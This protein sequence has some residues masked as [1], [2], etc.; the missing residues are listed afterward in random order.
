MVL[1]GY[2]FRHTISDRVQSCPFEVR[3]HLAVSKHILPRERLAEISGAFNP[4][5]FSMQQKLSSDTIPKLVSVN[6]YYYESR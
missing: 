4:S 1:I 2:D 6:R 3:S 5:S